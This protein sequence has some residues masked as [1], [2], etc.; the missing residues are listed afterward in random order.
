MSLHFFSRE[1]AMR[2]SRGPAT[3][4]YR[5]PATGSSTWDPV[6]TFVQFPPSL[7]YN[8]SSHPPPWQRRL[9]TKTPSLSLKNRKFSWSQKESK[10]VKHSPG[11][12]WQHTMMKNFSTQPLIIHMESIWNWRLLISIQFRCYSTYLFG[13]LD[14]LQLIAHGQLNVYINF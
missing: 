4:F 3:G 1:P 11:H 8:T 2:T 7:S 5:G 14:N 9:L 6:G 13:R 10:F 12:D